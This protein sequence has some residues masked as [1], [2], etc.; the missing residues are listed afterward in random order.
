VTNENLN[1]KKEILSL[2]NQ[3]EQYIDQLADDGV[4]NSEGR[5]V[6][7][8]LIRKLSTLTPETKTFAL[9]LKKTDQEQNFLAIIKEIKYYIES[10]F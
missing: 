3:I 8:L 6:K 2:I 10:S 1:K 9:R 5:K 4:L 7:W